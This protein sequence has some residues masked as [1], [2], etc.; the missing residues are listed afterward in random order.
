MTNLSDWD[1]RKAKAKAAGYPTVYQ[2]RKAAMLAQGKQPAKRKRD[3]K[4]EYAAV[5]NKAKRLGFTSERQLR[6]A[7]REWKA[8]PVAGVSNSITY[9]ECERWSNRRAVTSIARFEP[10]EAK[11]LGMTLD[12]YVT[13]Y[14]KA[15]VQDYYPTRHKGGSAPMKYWLVDILEYYSA[16]EYDGKYQG[17]GL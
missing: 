14:H 15:W 2:Y 13:A 17:Y 6:A 8:A 11:S 5:K 4:R 16:E 7:R 10:S 9:K 3:F 12:Q 1:R